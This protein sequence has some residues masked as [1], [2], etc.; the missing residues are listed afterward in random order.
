MEKFRN[1]DENFQAPRRKWGVC[2]WRLESYLTEDFKISITKSSVSVRACCLLLLVFLVVFVRFC[3]WAHDCKSACACVCVCVRGVCVCVCVCVMAS[4]PF[5][6]RVTE[7]LF[8]LYGVFYIRFHGNYLYQKTTLIFNS[9]CELSLRL[10]IFECSN[11]LTEV[12]MNLTKG[13]LTS[14]SFW[15]K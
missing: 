9:Y 10:L 15:T 5:F 13:S 8:V 6:Y 12:I 4:N 14:F 1:F 11:P 7:V 2:F 3:L